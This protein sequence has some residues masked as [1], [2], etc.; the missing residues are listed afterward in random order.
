MVA[1]PDLQEKAP[2][3]IAL[4]KLALDEPCNWGHQELGVNLLSDKFTGKGVKIALI[5]SGIAPH[6]G[7][8]VA[9]GYNALE[10]AAAD[11]W[12]GD[13]K[14]QGTH[15][16]GI[17][18]AKVNRASGIRG[19]APA[20]DI[21]AVKVSPGGRFSDLVEA[22][23]WCID[24]CMDVISI[25]LGSR[26][27]SPQVEQALMNAYLRG[28]TCVAA[29]GN[30]AGRVSYPAA[31]SHVIA[32]SAVGRKGTFP[33]A[34][35]H[36]LKAGR[37]VGYDGDAFFANFSNFGAEIDVCA[38]G[39][40]IPSTVPK[41]YAAWDG[42]SMAC[43]HVAGLVA[44]I[45]E[46]YPELRTA[47][48]YQPYYVRLL[49][50]DSATDL[51][52]PAEMQGAGMANVAAALESACAR[53]VEEEHN[54]AVYREYLQGMLERSKQALRVIEESLSRLETL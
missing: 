1:C 46:A 11:D 22:I 21:F 31:Y 17:V 15:C 10:G 42:T 49:I 2:L 18:G 6:R 25:S 27:P 43:T 45:L 23:N 38:P 36:G 50:T 4:Q 32:V 19:M 26:T 48:S 24:N 7:L 52:L 8:R 47:D 30:D 53:R 41:G 12:Q 13:E 5:D 33:A 35:A 9:G 28:I 51:G 16:C 34:S 29:A 37:Q 40:A 44:L 14:G 39:V 54:V 20:A 3:E